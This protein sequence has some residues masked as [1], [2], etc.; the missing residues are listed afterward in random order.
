LKLFFSGVGSGPFVP[1]V[2]TSNVYFPG[3]RCLYVLGEWHDLNA[4]FLPCLSAHWKLFAVPI[5][6]NL[7]EA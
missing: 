7:N 3:F 2:R 4:A 6:V 1:T 5:A